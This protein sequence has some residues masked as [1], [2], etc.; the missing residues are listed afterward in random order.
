[1]FLDSSTLIWPLCENNDSS[2][3]D[4]YIPYTPKCVY[5]APYLLLINPD[6]FPAPLLALAGHKNR[7][8]RHTHTSPP[9]S[10]SPPFLYNL[11]ENAGK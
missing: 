11:D 9:Y 3:S 2:P 4:S 1:M 6:I 10:L 8:H 7:F 5:L